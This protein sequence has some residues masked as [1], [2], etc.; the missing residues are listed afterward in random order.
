[1]RCGLGCVFRTCADL[2]ANQRLRE[3]L[4]PAAHPP[5]TNIINLCAAA[6]A[7]PPH[8]FDV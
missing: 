5:N 7:A 4:M 6:L 2:Q 1:M 8:R 3:A